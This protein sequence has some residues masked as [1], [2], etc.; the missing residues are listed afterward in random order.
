MRKGGAGRQSSLPMVTLLLRASAWIQTRQP[1]S[2]LH[3]YCFLLPSGSLGLCT[4]RTGLLTG[5]HATTN[6]CIR[7]TLIHF[8]ST[9]FHHLATFL[10][11]WEMLVC[12]H[13][14][15]LRFE[16]PQTS[17]L[18]VPMSPAGSRIGV[19]NVQH[20]TPKQFTGWTTTKLLFGPH[21]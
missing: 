3:F 20:Q 21:R 14:S 6:A 4:R 1:V 13:I 7:S 17:K 16:A 18:W 15:Q 12:S 9:I 8:L 11:K 2:C 10:L 5:H 19:K